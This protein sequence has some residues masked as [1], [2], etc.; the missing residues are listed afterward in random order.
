MSRPRIH[1][2]NAARQRAYRRRTATI[3]E[4]PQAPPS[5]PRR[6]TSRPARLAVLRIEAEALRQED[7]GWLDSLP[8]SLQDGDQGARL[9]ETIEQLGLV[10]DTLSEI[11]PPRGFGRD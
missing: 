10:V 2:S 11:N 1:A 3:R 4:A 6:A 5:P 8:D 7:Q 9:A